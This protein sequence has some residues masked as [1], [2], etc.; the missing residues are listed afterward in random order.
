MSKSKKEFEE[1]LGVSSMDES[2][3]NY[4]P[5]SLPFSQ[6]LHILLNDTQEGID[7]K[8]RRQKNEISAKEFRL[9]LIEISKKYRHLIV[10]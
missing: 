6:A 7:L 4:K 8:E 2:S 1:T 5:K 3:L 10:R 9:E